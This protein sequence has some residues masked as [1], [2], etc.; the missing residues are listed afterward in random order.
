MIFPP[1]LAQLGTVQIK[2]LA[3]SALFRG[4]RVGPNSIFGKGQLAIGY[5]AAYER[6]GVFRTVL[7]HPVARLRRA[8]LNGPFSA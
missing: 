5:P 6:T 2:L 7:Y 3:P 1:V 8:Q 4:W